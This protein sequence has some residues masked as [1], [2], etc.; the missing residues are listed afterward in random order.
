MTF[1]SNS[2]DLVPH[3]EIILDDDLQFFLHE[4][5][6]GIISGTLVCIT[7]QC[8]LTTLVLQANLSRE[9]NQHLNS[10]CLSNIYAIN[11]VQ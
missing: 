1:K 7:Y 10:L 3:V 4:N 6:G 11:I 2:T 8:R 9:D 5:L